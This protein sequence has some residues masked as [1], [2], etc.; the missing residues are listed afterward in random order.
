MRAEPP[1]ANLLAPLGRHQ[2]GPGEADDAGPAQAGRRL[3]QRAAGKDVAVAQ[4]FE[5]V[6][7]ADIQIAGDA[8]VLEGVVQHE[9]LAAEPC[10]RL[11]GPGDA[12]AVLHVGHVGESLVEFPGLVVLGRRVALDAA[13]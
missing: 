3:S 5:G 11:P 8:A 12:V 6:E 2:V 10:D 1:S 4:W 13:R 9:G 7:Q